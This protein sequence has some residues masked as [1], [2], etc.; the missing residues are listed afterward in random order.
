MK[1]KMM[2]CILAFLILTIIFFGKSILIHY[3]VFTGFSDNTIP[4]RR[5]KYIDKVSK[6]GE[7]AF[8]VLIRCLE[9]T[10]PM[11][12]ESAIVCL[13][14][15]TGKN[16]G[17]FEHYEIINGDT[18]WLTFEQQKQKEKQAIQKWKEYI[19]SLQGND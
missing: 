6:F 11:E 14:K 7:D 9:G 8:P 15:I 2:F 12:R 17:Y 18:T 16:F 4:G 10:F 13:Q 1:K 3:Y 19:Q 5:A